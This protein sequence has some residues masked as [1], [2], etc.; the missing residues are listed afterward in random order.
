MS[1]GR[2]CSQCPNCVTRRMKPPPPRARRASARN[3][4]SSCSIVPPATQGLCARRCRPLP[5]PCPPRGPVLRMRRVR[6]PGPTQA[7][8]PP[9]PPAPKSSTAP[10]ESG[11]S[12]AGQNPKT[13][14]PST[15]SPAPAPGPFPPVSLSV[16][17][18]LWLCVS[19]PLVGLSP[20]A[21]TLAL[22]QISDSMGVS[23]TL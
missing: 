8:Q 16:S 14:G 18:S 2:P 4:R 11:V 17:A 13:V 1:Q 5:S 9:T 20:G 6:K 21:R 19:L 22:T 3:Q 23:I 15:F 12:G 7:P 10:S